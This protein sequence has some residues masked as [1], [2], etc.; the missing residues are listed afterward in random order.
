MIN[1]YTGVVPSTFQVVHSLKLTYI[2]SEKRGFPK[3]KQ[4]YSKTIHFQVR[5]VSFREY[6]YIYKW[7]F[8]GCHL[9]LGYLTRNLLV[10]GGFHTDPFRRMC[11][12]PSPSGTPKMEGERTIGLFVTQFLVRFFF[13]RAPEMEV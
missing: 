9:S 2:A 13:F 6:I 1:Q 10:A 7:K 12:N 11:F 4:S 8:T 3:M 5:T